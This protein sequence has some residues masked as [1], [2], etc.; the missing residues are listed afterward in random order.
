MQCIEKCKTFHLA[1]CERQCGIIF[2]LCLSQIL[3]NCDYM[4]LGSNCIW[5]FYLLSMCVCRVLG[6]WTF[7]ILEILETLHAC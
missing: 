7:I 3:R 1:V 4:A 5:R 2:S 6:S